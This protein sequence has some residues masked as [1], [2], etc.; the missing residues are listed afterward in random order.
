V[1]LLRGGAPEARGR[2]QI[3]RLEIDDLSPNLPHLLALAL[4]AVLDKVAM[5]LGWKQPT[6][7]HVVIDT[8]HGT[9]RV[10]LRL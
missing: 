5:P 6:G 8:G 7:N 2:E 10:S 9:R 4:G 1:L 3:L